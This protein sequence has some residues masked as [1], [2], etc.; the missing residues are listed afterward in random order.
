[1]QTFVPGSKTFLK[2][3]A[4]RRNAVVQRSV[5]VKVAAVRFSKQLMRHNLALMTHTAQSTARARR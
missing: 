2:G 5:A 3:S 4:L 1:M